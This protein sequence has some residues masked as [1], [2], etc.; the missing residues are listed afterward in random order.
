MCG[1]AGVLGGASVLGGRMGGRLYTVVDAVVR[2]TMYGATRK[3]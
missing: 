3:W 2:G 1:V